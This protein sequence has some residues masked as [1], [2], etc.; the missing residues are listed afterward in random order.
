MFEKTAKENQSLDFVSIEKY[1]LTIEEIKNALKPWADIFKDKVEILCDLYPI[2]ARG[3]H[4]V[5]INNQITLTLVFD[6]VNEV[7]PTLIEK[8]DC[9]FLDGFTP[10]KNPQM[11]T[12][13]LFENMARLSNPY[14]S[15]ATFT[16][17]RFV[18][19]GLES[20]GFTVQKQKGFGYKPDMT[21]GFIQKEDKSRTSKIKQGASI[22]IIGGGLSGTATAFILKQYG[23]NPVIYEASDSLGAGSSG[24]ECGFFNPRFCALWDFTAQFS[25]PAFAQFITMAKHADDEIE[26]NPCGALHLINTTEKEKRFSSMI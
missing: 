21:N 20:V 9:W 23:F 11:W 25:S 1:P 16:A 22:A 2:R 18:R 8:F 7:L 24:N 19:E 17:A 3:V 10:A 12:E 13:V 14:A 26:Y 6:D 4:R 15:F 5:K